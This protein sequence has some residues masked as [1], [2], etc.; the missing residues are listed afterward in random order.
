M[1]REEAVQKELPP[2][3]RPSERKG[4]GLVL[5]LVYG[6]I[7][8]TFCILFIVLTIVGATAATSIL[9]E[10]M[11]LPY[12][13]ESILALSVV[14]ATV[15]AVIYLRRL[16][17]LSLDGARRKWRYLAV[18]YGATL[19]VNVL[20]FQVVFPAAANL[21]M[22]ADISLS[23]SVASAAVSEASGVAS[24]TLAVEIPCSG[25]APLIISELES[26]SGVQN[27]EY[28]DDGL[29]FVAY[30]PALVSE[31]EILALPVFESFPVSLAPGG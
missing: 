3:C 16:G 9:R 31:E 26:A 29:F 23:A 12:L 25:H 27:V 7:P 13:F 2:C 24:L 22:R 17:L 14:F 18:M 6:L 10:V 30:D 28:T 20:L 4:H 19:A 8:H 1:T 15:S 21:P 11:L 5:G